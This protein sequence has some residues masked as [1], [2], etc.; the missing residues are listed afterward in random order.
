VNGVETALDLY[1]EEDDSENFSKAMETQ[2]LLAGR[3]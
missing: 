2:D 1:I 3:D